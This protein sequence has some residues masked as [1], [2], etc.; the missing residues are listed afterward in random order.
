M[1]YVDDVISGKEKVHI[2]VPR[3][4]KVEV[5]CSECD[6][7]MFIIDTNNIVSPVGTVCEKCL[8]RR[9]GRVR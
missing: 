5:R 3:L 7:F 2:K 9:G 4:L 6:E 8:N 1:T